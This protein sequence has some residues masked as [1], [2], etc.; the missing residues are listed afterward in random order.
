MYNSV[1]YDKVYTS[2][3]TVA[4]LLMLMKIISLI[5]KIFLPPELESTC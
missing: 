3:P 4:D 5:I 1:T 2:S